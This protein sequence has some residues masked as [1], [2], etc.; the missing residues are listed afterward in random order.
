MTLKVQVYSVLFSFGFGIFYLGSFYL[1]K[2]FLLYGRRLAKVIYNTMFMIFSVFI[3]FSV[4]TLINSG[5]LH[6]Y[7]LIAFL[8]GLSFCYFIL[9]KFVLKNFT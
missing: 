3:Y 4:L 6:Y 5:I 1:V 8:C 7:Y 9:I 2:K